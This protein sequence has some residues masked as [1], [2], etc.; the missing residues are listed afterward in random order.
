VC[1]FWIVF[2]KKKSLREKELGFGQTGE[3]KCI[4]FLRKKNREAFKEH[5]K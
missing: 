2:G 4:N 5:I 3:N 1:F